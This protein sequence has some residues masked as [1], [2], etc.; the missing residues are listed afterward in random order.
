MR[1]RKDLATGET[2]TTND[3]TT[4]PATT[5]T[6][7]YLLNDENYKLNYL[8]TL[9]GY[10]SLIESRDLREFF[11]LTDLRNV[12]YLLDALLSCVL[13]DY[14]SL[15]NFFTVDAA[16]P[17]NNRPVT[18]ELASNYD[19]LATF[20]NSRA[21]YAQLRLI[22]ANL[23]KSSLV[24]LLVDQLLFSKNR[25]GSGRLDQNEV[26][27]IANLLLNDM[28]KSSFLTE[29]EIFAILN[30]VLSNFMADSDD[31]DSDETDKNFISDA[32]RAITRTC[33]KIE[34]VRTI[35]QLVGN[36][37]ANNKRFQHKFLIDTLFLLLEHYLSKNLLVRAACAKCLAEL[38]VSLKFTSVQ[39]LLA[40]NFDYIMNDL[41]LKI[42]NAVK[43]H[44]DS[45]AT[46]NVLIL[47]SLIEIADNEIVF[48]LNRLVEDLFVACELEPSNGVLLNGVCSIMIRTAKAMRRWHAVRFDSVFVADGGGGDG[49]AEDGDFDFGM[50]DFEKLATSRRTKEYNRPF[51]DVLRE[52]EEGRVK[53][54]F[55]HGVSGVN[56]QNE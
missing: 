9:H 41:I 40:K 13:I 27:V 34:L 15:D 42:N 3:E 16:A 50:I 2:T 37:S 29:E 19:G 5:T 30:L 31:L 22:C 51:L 39:D 10:L 8:K 28:N 20:L 47:C 45:A 17:V 26:L 4:S 49:E 53:I 7:K 56:G 21:I 52:T 6:D 44:T 12:D 18:A 32:N 46:V 11:Q 33:L 48:Y 24:R 1:K 36:S 25:S 54:D 23:G 43:W 55:D 38:A 35:A 14:T